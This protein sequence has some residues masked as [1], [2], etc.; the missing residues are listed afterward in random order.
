MRKGG[1]EVE[2]GE[3]ERDGAHVGEITG[4]EEE[5]WDKGEEKDQQWLTI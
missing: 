4:D 1:V 3:E 2:Y 5:E